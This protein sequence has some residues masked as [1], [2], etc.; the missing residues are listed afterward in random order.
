MPN[1][2]LPVCN[3]E[4]VSAA[5]A[6]ALA[7]TCADPGHC[8]SPA[9]ELAAAALR[10]HGALSTG[11]GRSVPVTGWGPGGGGVRGLAVFL[12][13]YAAQQEQQD[14]QSPGAAV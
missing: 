11:W 5:W 12:A 14:V 10:T 7:M 9:G 6:E 8:H 4:T 3:A 13:V 2:K 1:P